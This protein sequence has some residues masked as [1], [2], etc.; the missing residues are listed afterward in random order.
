MNTFSKIIIFIV[1]CAAGWWAYDS[2]LADKI[3]LP[4]LSTEK[5][6]EILL[7]NKNN[8]E[9][10]NSVNETNEPVN[11]EKEQSILV[12]MLTTDKSGTQFLKPVV[13]PLPPGKDKLSYAVEQLF[14]GPNHNETSKGIYSE[15]PSSAKLV[16]VTDSESKVIVDVTGSFSY[17]G[18]SDS[19]YSRVRQLVKT[20]LANTNKPVYLYIDGKQ[21]DVIGGEGISLTQPLSEKSLDE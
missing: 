11:P 5:D 7:P 10:Q 14:V 15:I 4:N 18:G 3:K 16:A 19:I 9:K 21:A 12:Y 20:T 2:F 17:G 6:T 13:R 1:I 8:E